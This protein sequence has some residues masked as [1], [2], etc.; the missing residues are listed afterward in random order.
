MIE[1]KAGPAALGID[2]GGFVGEVV[3]AFLG[4]LALLALISIVRGAT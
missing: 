3:Q 2:P 1:G 4:A